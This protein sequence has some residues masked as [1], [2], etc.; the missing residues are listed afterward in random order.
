M[1]LKFHGRAAA[2]DSKGWASIAW[3]GTGAP[4]H[5]SAVYDENDDWHVFRIA[6]Q[7]DVVRMYIDDQKAPIYEETVFLADR[8]DGLMSFGDWG[9]S[10]LGSAQLD[11]IRWDDTQAIFA[12][13]IVPEPGTL[14]LTLLAAAG[15]ATRRRR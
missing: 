10:V 12:R 15:V 2:D 6:A 7:D 13:P 11:Y 9:S 5:N 4:N 1:I 3:S 14:G 8:G